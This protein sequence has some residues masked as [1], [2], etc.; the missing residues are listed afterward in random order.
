MSSERAVNATA[1]GQD[2]RFYAEGEGYTTLEIADG[3]AALLLELMQ[4][5]E[6]SE[7]ADVMEVIDALYD[8]V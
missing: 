6:G 5:A 1:L 2:L 3:A 4:S 8:K 7:Q